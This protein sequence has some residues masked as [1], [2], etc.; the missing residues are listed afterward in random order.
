MNKK[1]K[2]NVYIIFLVF[3][4][5]ISCQILNRDK[6][7]IGALNQ[8]NSLDN[9]KTLNHELSKTDFG[10]AIS[11][12]PHFF[13]KNSNHEATINILTRLEKYYKE[14]RINALFI[15]GDFF[16]IGGIRENW[17]KFIEIK[18][19]ISPTLKVYS[20]IGNH[21]KYF[22]GSKYWK[23]IFQNVNT[24]QID[25]N[26]IKMK[27]FNDYTWHYNY[28]N[29]HF[30]GLNLP[31]NNNYTSEAEKKWISKE[32]EQ[33]EDEDFLIILSHSFFWASGY[34]DL[35][36]NWFD[37]KNNIKNIFPIFSNKAKLVV[38]GHNHYM[39]WI[40]KEGISYAIVGA[41]GGKP[42]PEPS[43][44][45]NGS[46]WF[47]RGKFGYL[48]IEKKGNKIYIS[49]EDQF[50]NTLFEKIIESPKKWNKIG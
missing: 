46:V 9:E 19:E 24:N 43:Y 26:E 23:M 21:D 15:L 25:N 14:G 34:K 31:F 17:I 33:I 48:L 8:E 32:I 13:S 2:I 27:K 12:D 35:S 30:I 5:F 4:I 16:D 49:F 28:K 36:G 18:K 38:S 47:N 45:T 37:N 3:F 6:I 22:G 29:F 41:M 44:I 39:E 40:E 42:D 50:G 11:S 1:I 7:L 20:V 10:F